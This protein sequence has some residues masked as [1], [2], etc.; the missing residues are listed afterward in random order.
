MVEALSFL[1]SNSIA[2]SE[3]S[4]LNWQSLLLTARSL[5]CLG[6]ASC[7]SFAPFF[8]R[9]SKK[10]RVIFKSISKGACD[11]AVLIDGER[12]DV[13]VVSDYQD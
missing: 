10:Q 1:F 7:C 4:Q 8:A 3:K 12:L 2:S 6:I 5:T 11:R 13:A 9:L